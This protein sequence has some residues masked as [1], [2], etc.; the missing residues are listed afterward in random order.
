M[1]EIISEMLM[2]DKEIRNK[3]PDSFH[4]NDG[5]YST[6]EIDSMK[7]VRRKIDKYNTEKLIELTKEY[8]WI[9]GERIDCSDLD[10]WLIFRH[11]DPKYFDEISKLIKKE[12]DAKRISEW[13]YKLIKNHLEGRPH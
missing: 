6:K 11:S 5:T 8:G 13:H 7:L 1:C 10:T 3:I 9:S 4:K 12:Y 2:K